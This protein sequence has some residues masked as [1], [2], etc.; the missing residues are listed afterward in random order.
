MSLP[1]FG[2]P[3]RRLR[4]PS[5]VAAKENTAPGVGRANLVGVGT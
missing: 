5:V 3:G 2:L 1:K 4:G